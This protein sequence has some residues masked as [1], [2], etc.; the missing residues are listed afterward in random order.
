MAKFTLIHFPG[1]KQ[2]PLRCVI[3]SGHCAFLYTM[4]QF[5]TK[6]NNTI[7][8]QQNT[9]Q[10]GFDKLESSEVSLKLQHALVST[11]VDL[12]PVEELEVA[13]TCKC[14]S[15]QTPWLKM[16]LWLNSKP[17]RYHWLSPPPLPLHQLY[18]LANHQL[19][20]DFLSHLLLPLIS[21]GNLQRSSP[22]FLP[23]TRPRKESRVKERRMTAMRVVCFHLYCHK[24]GAAFQ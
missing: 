23:S 13:A 3:Y 1:D 22:F 9:I 7:L 4:L 14:Q 2:A 8:C 16:W 24:W 5:A 17:L 18:G 12:F 10:S 20:L 19:F 21:Q 15:S 11:N 6:R